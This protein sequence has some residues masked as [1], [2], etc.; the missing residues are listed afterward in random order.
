MNEQI[1]DVDIVCQKT[2]RVKVTDDMIEKGESAKDVAD[3]LA[4]E[5]FWNPGWADIEEL[6]TDLSIE[7]VVPVEDGNG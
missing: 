1:F 7:R 3:E 5:N 6:D 2:L 4:M